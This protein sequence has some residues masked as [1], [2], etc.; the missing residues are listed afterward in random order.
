MSHVL[1][2][3]IHV[4]TDAVEQSWNANRSNDRESPRAHEMQRLAFPPSQYMQEEDS[5]DSDAPGPGTDSRKDPV[6]ILRSKVNNLP[7]VSKYS[8]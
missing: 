2:T 5:S 4:A 6:T 3:A 8:F 1:T 7:P